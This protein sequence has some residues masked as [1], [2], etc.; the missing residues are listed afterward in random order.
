MEKYWNGIE[1]SN[2]K[3]VSN[4][5]GGSY[6]CNGNLNIHEKFYIDM[7]DGTKHVLHYI[8]HEGK[9][10]GEEAR[11]EV[12]KI[13]NE[14]NKIPEVYLVTNNTFIEVDGEQLEFGV[15]VENILGQNLYFTIK[16]FFDLKKQFTVKDD[17]GRN[18]S[19]I[20][21]FSIQGNRV[22]NPIPQNYVDQLEYMGYDINKLEYELK[23]E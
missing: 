7:K 18:L 9:R 15:Q 20:Q 1:I 11:V 5:C 13:F 14:Y 6:G 4:G 21:K 19:Y 23:S 2:I 10:E 22:S 12:K 3:H 17:G 8:S 16:E